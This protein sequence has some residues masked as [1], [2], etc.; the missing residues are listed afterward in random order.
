MK[1]RNLLA[2]GLAMAG[3]A[4]M[5]QAQTYYN[6]NYVGRDL[7][8]RDNLVRR[9]EADRRQVERERID[10]RYANRYNAGREFRELNAAHARLEC[11]RRE[12]RAAR[13]YPGRW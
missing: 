1:S 2:I 7:R 8:M 6:G 4:T 12:L 11:D 10:L 9:V 5:A 13:A 3:F